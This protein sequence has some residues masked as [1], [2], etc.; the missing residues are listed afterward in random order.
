MEIS[1]LSRNLDAMHAVESRFY[2]PPVVSL[3][4][5]GGSMMYGT[6]QSSDSECR[7][8]VQSVAIQRNIVKVESL[9]TAT[10]DEHHCS[11]QGEYKASRNS[12][13]PVSSGFVLLRQSCIVHKNSLM[14]CAIFRSGKLNRV[15]PCH[16]FL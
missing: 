7:T 8:R 10:A 3:D 11:E 1:Q 15:R 2:P 14:S 13:K 9:E 6:G 4:D 12:T 5:D 16:G